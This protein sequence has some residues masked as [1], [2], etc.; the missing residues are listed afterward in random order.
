MAGS[1]LRACLAIVSDVDSGEHLIVALAGFEG[2]VDV[3]SRH[4]V[5]WG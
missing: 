5:Q 1:D 4:T 2:A 3:G